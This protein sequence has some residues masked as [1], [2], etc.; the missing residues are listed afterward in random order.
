MIPDKVHLRILTPEREVFSD[1]V[2][3]VQLPGVG[4]YFGIYPGH[5]PYVSALKIGEIKIGTEG[6]ENS[7]A[8]TGGVVEVLPTGISVLAETCESENDIDVKRAKEARDRAKKRID[9][10]RKN[11]DVGRAQVALARAINR[12]GVSSQ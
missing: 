4:G 8:T 11:W 9:E 3:S 7:F 10:G 1:N 5:T 2:S 12:L 6:K